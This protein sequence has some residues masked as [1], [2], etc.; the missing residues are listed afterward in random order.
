MPVIPP[1]LNRLEYGHYSR[2]CIREVCGRVQRR[3]YF[4]RI[5]IMTQTAQLLRHLRTCRLSTGAFEGQSLDLGW[6]RVFGGQVCA[7]L[8]R[9]FQESLRSQTTDRDTPVDNV[10]TVLTCWAPTLRTRARALTHSRTHAHTHARTSCPILYGSK[11][12]AQGLHAAGQ[13]VTTDQYILHSAHTHFLR[14][15]NV[16]IPVQYTVDSLLDGR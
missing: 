5:L 14:P 13:T 9:A 16:D 3:S 6:G 7:G 12:V 11:V 2:V 15:G 4:A 1:G 8:C 10:H